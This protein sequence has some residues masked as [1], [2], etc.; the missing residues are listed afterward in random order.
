[1]GR[2]GVVRDYV[3]PVKLCCMREHLRPVAYQVLTVMKRAV[4]ARH[5]ET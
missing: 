1:M 2:I 3:L 4:S 5:A